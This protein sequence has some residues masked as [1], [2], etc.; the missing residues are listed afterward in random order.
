MD[1]TFF[2]VSNCIRDYIKSRAPGI[3][4]HFGRAY[5]K[6]FRQIMKWQ[7][8]RF[9]DGSIVERGGYKYRLHKQEHISR[10]LFAKGRY[11]EMEKQIL[12]HS[13]S[14]MKS[15]ID[16]G[17]NI[18]LLTI[19]VA[20]RIQVPT[21]AIE[22]VKSNYS[23]LL[24]NICLNGLENL[25]VAKQVAFSQEFGT[26]NIYLCDENSGDHRLSKEIG[27]SRKTEEVV[28]KTFDECLLNSSQFAAPRLIKMDVQGNEVKVLLGGPKKFLD[29]C[30]IVSEFCPSSLRVASSSPNEFDQV[31]K[32]YFLDSFEVV[33]EDRSFHLRKIESLV[34]LALRIP[35][36]KD[37]T[38]VLANIPLVET[39]LR[40]YIR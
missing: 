21:L 33:P 15:F 8:D 9:Y 40:D 16:I 13:A 6:F 22:P 7:Y 28:V 34:D 2:A 25:V 5:G 17:A 32:H 27:E 23:L 26:A 37:C 36:G 35:Y 3:S 39:G 4:P 12:Q 38:I 24:E 29:P 14:G 31:R 30:I 11:G 1:D 18:G 20:H 19:P 10:Q